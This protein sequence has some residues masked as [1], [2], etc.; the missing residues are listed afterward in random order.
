MELSQKIVWNLYSTTIAA[1]SGIVASKAVDA[2][3]SFVTGDEPPEPN[4]P[5]TPTGI[6]VA[7]VA[8]L[9]LGVGLSQVL[10]N[11]LAARHWQQQTGLSS[12]VRSVNLKL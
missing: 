1:L 11:R 4:D 2:A 8:A 12:P 9:A 3:W 6:A 5:N 10:T 7:R